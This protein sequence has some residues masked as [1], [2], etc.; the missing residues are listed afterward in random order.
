[1]LDLNLFTE[2]LDVPAVF[3]QAL[4]TTVFSGSCTCVHSY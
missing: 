1:M 3:L 2:G 4:K